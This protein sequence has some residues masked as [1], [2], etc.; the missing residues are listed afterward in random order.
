MRGEPIMADLASRVAI[1]NGAG[2]GIG[3][4]VAVRLSEAGATVVATSRTREHL[5][6][7]LDA[8]ERVT[9]ERPLGIDLAHS[10]KLEMTSDE[11]WNSVLDV[12]VTGFFRFC[13]AVLPHL[14]EG[15]SIINMGSVNSLVGWPDDA[16]YTTSKGAV[17]LFTRALALELAQRKIRVNCVCPGV[18]DTPLSESFLRRAPDPAALRR[19]YELYSPL[20]RMGTAR[21]VANCVA[22]LASDEASFVTGSAL[23]VDGGATAR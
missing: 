12:N 17:L 1:V 10:P 14:R 16:P 6:G 21:E 22:F 20:G 3:R 4:A 2:S 19:E 18:I 15:A 23:V 8:L 7:T 11:E 13:R 5:A 9:G